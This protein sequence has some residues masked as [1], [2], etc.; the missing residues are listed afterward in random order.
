[1]KKVFLALLASGESRVPPDIL[2][3]QEL[4]VILE[5]MENLVGQAF[6]DLKVTE[7]ILVLLDHLGFRVY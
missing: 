1:V 6:L 5:T 7:A 2:G 3:K 4:R